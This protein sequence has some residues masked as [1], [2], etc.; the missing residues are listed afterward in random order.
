M[1]KEIKIVTI[2]AETD[3]ELETQLTALGEDIIQVENTMPHIA[4]RNREF[5]VYYTVNI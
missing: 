2:V 4:R 1:A 5:K 3:E